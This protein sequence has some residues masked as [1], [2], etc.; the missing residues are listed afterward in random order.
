MIKNERDEQPRKNRIEGDYQEPEYITIT[1]TDPITHE[2][3]GKNSHTSYLLTT[4]TSFPEYKDTHLQVRRRYSDFVWLRNHLKRK[5]EESP[6]GRKKGGT[7][8]ALPGDTFSSL[9]GPSRFDP[10]FIEERRLGLEAFVNSVANHV[11]C[12]FEPALHA[13][14]QDPSDDRFKEFN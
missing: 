8:P 13:F 10:A 11:I 7:I 3:N 2:I 12:R 4:D 9:F 5:M 14:L 6:K 1:I